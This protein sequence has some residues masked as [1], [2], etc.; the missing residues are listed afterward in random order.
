MF[1][2]MKC[3]HGSVLHCYEI[4][5]LI[6]IIRSMWLTLN[7]LNC[8]KD[9]EGYIHILN[10]ILVL[11]SLKLVKLT[12]EQQY[13]LSILHSQ[14]HACW[15]SGDFRSQG[16][17]RYGIAPP[18]PPPP[19]PMLEYSVSN[20]RR[21]NLPIFPRVTLLAPGSAYYSSSASE[22]TLKDMV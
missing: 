1:Y 3:A 22:M 18:P 16:I 7:M 9:C 21:V 4:V 19:P 13:M 10:R 20:I 15:C 2:P 17:S 11:A 12:P 6:I 14:Y 8:F 5:L